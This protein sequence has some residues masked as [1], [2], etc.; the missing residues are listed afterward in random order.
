MDQYTVQMDERNRH[1]YKKV[2]MSYYQMRKVMCRMIGRVY[3]FKNQ[4][5]GASPMAE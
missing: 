1:S 5:L 2:P 3:S 4:T